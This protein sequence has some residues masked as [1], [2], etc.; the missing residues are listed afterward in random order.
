MYHVEPDVCRSPCSVINQRIN[1]NQWVTRALLQ[2][3]VTEENRLG[4]QK[5]NK[6]ITGKRLLLRFS[7][8]VLS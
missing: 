6:N 5:E 3:D 8:S 4:P 7:F 2:E 1:Y